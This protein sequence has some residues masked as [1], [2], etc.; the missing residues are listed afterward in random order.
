ME[1]RTNQNRDTVAETEQIPNT[2]GG[3]EIELQDV[4]FR[5]PTR[6]IAIFK[7][8]NMHVSHLE[9][10]SRIRATVLIDRRF[11]RANLL[12]SW[13]L[14]VCLSVLHKLYYAYMLEGCGKTSIVSLLERWAQLNPSLCIK[15]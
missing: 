4:Y 10:L 12:L 7:G 13:E 14:Q 1:A 9:A 8:L 11:K 3:I 6:D 15:T 5:Y 2:V